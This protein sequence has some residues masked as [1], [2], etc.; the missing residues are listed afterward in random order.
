MDAQ[1]T[2]TQ[3]FRHYSRTHRVVAWIS[4]K[5]C[6]RLTYTQRHGLIKGMLRRGGLG[7]LPSF[8]SG[9]T[10]TGEHAFWSRQDLR[11]L[12][13]YDIGAF[14]GLLTMFFAKQA[15]Q[16][17]AYEPYSRNYVRLAENIALNRLTNVTLRK[18]ALGS[19][20]ESAV[21]TALPLMPGGA[22]VDTDARA[23]M[24]ASA[25]HTIS[26]EISLT[27]LDDDIREQS[28]PPPDFVKIDVEG[29]E[30]AVIQ[31]ARQTLLLHKV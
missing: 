26:E 10:I 11:D 22:T 12:V 14:Q 16:V 8:A 28:L 7:W 27:T 20:Q 3:P 4:E 18:V 23:Y 5:V 6:G 13:I 25:P 31:G 1:H 21:A 24:H 9:S 29:A 30:L 17:V 15:R 19:K 2:E